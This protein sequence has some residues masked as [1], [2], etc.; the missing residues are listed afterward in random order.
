MNVRASGD[1]LGG[2]EA[3]ILEDPKP[4]AMYQDANNRR[5]SKSPALDPRDFAKAVLQNCGEI[6]IKDN[7]VPTCR[8]GTD[9]MRK[10]GGILSP[11]PARTFFG[12]GSKNALKAYTLAAEASQTE[13][14]AT[15]R[16]SR[17]SPFETG[18]RNSRG[19]FSDISGQSSIMMINNNMD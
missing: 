13:Q 4:D 15:A 1:T 7:C 9:F 14:A 19:L 5:G 8:T 3:K 17:H 11:D 6:R 10:V 12:L 2:S 16:L 18:A